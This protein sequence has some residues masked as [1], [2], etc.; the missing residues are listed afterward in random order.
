MMAPV[1][2]RN[3][4]LRGGKLALA[5]PMPGLL[6][7]GRADGYVRGAGGP[8]GVID[9]ALWTEGAELMLAYGIL[10]ALPDLPGTLAPGYFG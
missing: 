6:G 10:D 2:R 4:M 9:P 8:I 7:A 5:V 1:T 3:V